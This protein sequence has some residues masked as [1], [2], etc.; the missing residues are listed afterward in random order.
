[1]FNSEA[2][3]TKGRTG[4]G[5]RRQLPTSRAGYVA[6]RGPDVPGRIADLRRSGTE[7]GIVIATLSPTLSGK[8]EPEAPTPRDRLQILSR[9]SAEGVGTGLE[10]CPV[11]PGITDRLST[12]EALVRA[13]AGCG[14]VWVRA[15]GL[16]LP[17][18][19]KPS[20]YRF[21]EKERRGLVRRYRRRYRDT[22]EPPRLW[23][24]GLQAMVRELRIHAGLLPGPPRSGPEGQ[25]ALPF[26]VAEGGIEYS[27][28]S[29]LP[30]GAGHI[31][32]REPR[33]LAGLRG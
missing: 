3:H 25:L 15:H 2:Q 5:G 7:V 4:R 26:T 10:I 21:L 27:G 13:A 20:F 32:G 16:R 28:R 9:L 12:L 33:A 23:E 8:L 31:P 29:R 22:A 1:M 14:A 19:A 30:E 18:A 6:V 11:L 17:A 24:E